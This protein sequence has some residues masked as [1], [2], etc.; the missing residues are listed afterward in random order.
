MK[1]RGAEAVFDYRD[2]DCAAEIRAF[3]SNNLRYALDCITT[4]DS[5]QTCYKALGRAGGRY[6]SLDPYSEHVAATR[7]VVKPDWVLGPAI[8]GQGCTWPDPYGRSADTEL[9][10]FGVELWALAQKLLEQGKLQHHP[11]KILD[12]GLEAVVDGMDLVREGPLSGQK[13]VVRL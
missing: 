11:L 10:Q 2:P 9:Q 12:G 3:T 13:V 8:F 1:S 7:K 4:L 5:T 6:V